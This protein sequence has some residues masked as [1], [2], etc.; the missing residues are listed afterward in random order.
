MRLSVECAFSHLRKRGATSRKDAFCADGLTQKRSLH[1]AT[2]AKAHSGGVALTEKR[3]LQPAAHAK[4]HSAQTVSRKSA[5]WI[6]ISRKSALCNRHLTQKRILRRRCH[7]D[8]TKRRILDGRRHGKAH[9]ACGAHQ[10]AHSVC[11]R[12]RRVRLSVRVRAQNA[13]FRRMCFASPAQTWGRLTE[14]RTLQ[15]LAHGKAHSATAGS[16]KSAL[17]IGISRKSAV[18]NRWL[19]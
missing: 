11:E 14:K 5:L 9:F 17:W 7:L 2:H 18:C 15:P 8:V 13:L 6:G 12:S 1:P 19:T 10:K 16:R 3:I 4:A